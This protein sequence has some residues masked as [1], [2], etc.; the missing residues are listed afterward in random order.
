M[1]RM[2][3][4]CAGLDVHKKLIV[5]CRLTID[6]RGQTHKAVSKF[7]TM[8]ADLETLAAWLAEG[9]CTHVAMESTGVFWRPIFNIL[10]ESVEVWVVNAHH[11]SM[12]RGGRP[13]SR[14]PS[15]S[16]S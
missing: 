4:N 11:V 8:T 13:T 12:C 16:R 1:E 3:P 7:G 9:G 14:T 15:G 2:F 6:G 10:Q 5:A